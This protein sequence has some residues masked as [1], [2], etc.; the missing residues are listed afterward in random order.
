MLIL[1]HV[2]CYRCILFS[3]KIFHANMWL[4]P[5]YFTRTYTRIV[6]D[7][8]K[9]RFFYHNRFLL[10]NYDFAWWNC[11]DYVNAGTFFSFG[12][13][14]VGKCCAYIFLALYLIVFLYIWII[15]IIFVNEYRFI[16]FDKMILD[17]LHRMEL[18]RTISR[19][20]KHWNV[21]DKVHYVYYFRFVRRLWIL[22]REI[23]ECKWNRSDC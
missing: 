18:F 3:L 20:N 16:F 1:V 22:K 11:R 15:S 12:I 19:R 7:L 21:V 23:L 6:L 17:S 2:Q 14:C 9:H 10:D 13:L 5:R 4:I 8:M